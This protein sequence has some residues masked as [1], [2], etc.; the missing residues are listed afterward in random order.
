MKYLINDKIHYDTGFK[1]NSNSVLQAVEKVNTAL[2]SL[3]DELYATMDYKSTSGLIGAFL[4]KNIS[5]VTGAIVN[6]IEKGHPDVVPKSAEDATEE[7]LRKYPEGLEIKVTAGNIKQGTKL[8]TGESRIQTLSSLTWQAHHRE[9]GS[10]MGCIWDFAGTK[11]TENAGFRNPIITG[12]FYS[13]DLTEDDWGAI[14]GTTGR[15]TKVS[16][17]KSSGKKKMGQGWVVLIEE[18]EYLKKYSKILDISL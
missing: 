7:E 10:L 5:N 12:V 9:V 1:I 17:M 13:T 2:E 16:G 18:D 11:S 15:N 6:P 4:A 3:P 14:S 8:K